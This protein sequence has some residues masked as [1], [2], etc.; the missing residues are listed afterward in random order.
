MYRLQNNKFKNF[1]KRAPPMSSCKTFISL[2]NELVCRKRKQK[3]LIG[4]KNGKKCAHGLTL[5]VGQ[6]FAKL[7][8]LWWILTRYFITFS[9]WFFS[10]WLFRKFKLEHY[11]KILVT[12]RVP[13]CFGLKSLTQKGQ[14]FHTLRPKSSTKKI[15]KEYQ[16][17]DINDST[18]PKLKSYTK[19]SEKNEI[20]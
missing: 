7:T 1:E 8:K 3:N 11:S 19:K 13:L 10:F 4:S 2:W 15:Y 9:F 17:Y 18:S 20:V 12:A 5:P 16:K 14:K 6:H